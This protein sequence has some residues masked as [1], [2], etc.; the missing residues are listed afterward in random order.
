M[1]KAIQRIL[2]H[3]P[4]E[5]KFSYGTFFSGKHCFLTCLGLHKTLK[6]LRLGRSRLL[7]F[8]QVVVGRKLMLDASK[9]HENYCFEAVVELMTCESI[10]LI[11]G[12]NK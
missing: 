1:L 11:V 10:C 3:F 5:S 12:D 6:V 9:Y 7:N 2:I 4:T 8:V